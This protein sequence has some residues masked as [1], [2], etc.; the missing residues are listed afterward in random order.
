M[1]SG[2]RPLKRQLEDS[3]KLHILKLFKSY[4]IPIPILIT[5][6]P[7]SEFVARIATLLACLTM[8]YY[9]MALLNDTVHGDGVRLCYLL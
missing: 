7:K 1:W 8:C 4:W 2:S 3:L 6:L 5:M 9:V